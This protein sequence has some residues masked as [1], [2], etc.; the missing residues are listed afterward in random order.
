MRAEPHHYEEVEGGTKDFTAHY[1]NFKNG[2]FKSTPKPGTSYN[3]A[4]GTDT[5]PEKGIYLED[6]TRVLSST[7]EPLADGNLF[8]SCL[9]PPHDTS[10]L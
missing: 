10:H 4:L 5:M 9:I 3:Y 2:L 8:D 7:C 1:C 6:V